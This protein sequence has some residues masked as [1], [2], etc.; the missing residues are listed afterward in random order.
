MGAKNQVRPLLD[1]ILDA[2]F[3]PRVK[4][5]SGAGLPGV[6]NQGYLIFS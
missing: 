4:L 3:V 6:K 5:G 1:V 2:E